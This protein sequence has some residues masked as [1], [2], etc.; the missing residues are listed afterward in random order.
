VAG[1]DQLFPRGRGAGAVDLREVRHRLLHRR[2]RA[3]LGVAHFL[4]LLLRLVAHPLQLV[5][6]LDDP[7]LPATPLRGGGIGLV[8]GRR[9]RVEAE[10][11]AVQRHRQQRIRCTRTGI[12]L[13]P[14][15]VSGASPGLLDP[16]H[17]LLGALLEPAH[18]LAGVAT[19]RRSGASPRVRHGS[20][21]GPGERSARRPRPPLR[22][23][24]WLPRATRASRPPRDGILALRLR[25]RRPAGRVGQPR[26]A[27]PRARPG[28][29][30]CPHR[31]L[32]PG[33]RARA[34]MDCVSAST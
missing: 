17:E 33:Q 34:G 30:R 31:R 18:P 9:G 23:R 25:S 7:I 2:G 12:L 5:L 20:R 29:S 32:A 8:E 1:R 16:F 24:R 3:A 19:P 22:T 21:H 27:P 10:T 4:A 14:P 13:A 11:A 15:S 28:A 6:E 26:R